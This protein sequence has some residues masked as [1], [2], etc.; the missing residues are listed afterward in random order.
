MVTVPR[1]RLRSCLHDAVRVPRR[2]SLYTRVGGGCNPDPRT[3]RS[4][5][6][7]TKVDGRTLG[8]SARV[9]FRSQDMIAEVD[10]PPKSYVVYAVVAPSYHFERLILQTSAGGRLESGGLR[11]SLLL[12]LHA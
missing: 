5:G 6:A 12:A 7:A 10:R 2:A 11:G 3:S 1:Y 9:A 8:D 4:D